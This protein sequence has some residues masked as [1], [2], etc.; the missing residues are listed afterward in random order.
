[1]INQRKGCPSKLVS[2]RNNRNSNRNCFRHYPKQNVCFGCF[3]SIPKQIVSVFRLN[4]N[5]QKSNRKGVIESICQHFFRKFR[6]VSVET[7][8]FV[9]VVSIYSVGSK[10]RKKPKLLVFGFMKQT[11]TQPKQILLRLVSVRTENFFVLF[12]GHLRSRNH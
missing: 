3:G 9:S 2:I 6:V 1:M 4:Q 10:H 7:V 12:L 11:E 5:N 8:L